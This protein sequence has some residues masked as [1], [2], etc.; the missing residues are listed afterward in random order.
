M[1]ARIIWALVNWQIFQAANWSLQPS[2]K[3]KGISILKFSKQIIKIT[4]IIRESI[5][6]VNGLKLWI[7]ERYIPMIKHLLIETK[8]GKISHCQ[9]LVGSFYKLS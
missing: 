2:K 1:I 9:M 7:K 5:D 8:K 3:A 6:D 4:A